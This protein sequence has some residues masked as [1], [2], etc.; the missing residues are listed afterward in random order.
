MLRLCGVTV[1]P[2]NSTLVVNQSHCFNLNDNFRAKNVFSTF[3]VALRCWSWSFQK[4][5]ISSRYTIQEF[6]VY[7]SSISSRAR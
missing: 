7:F 1:Q 5:K 3:L 6:H 4:V 2:R